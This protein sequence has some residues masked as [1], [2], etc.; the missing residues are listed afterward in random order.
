MLNN[1]KKIKTGSKPVLIFPK[2]V[3]LFQVERST[4]KK[5]L[6]VLEKQNNYSFLNLPEISRKNNLQKNLQTIVLKI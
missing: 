2:T 4:N 1:L 3:K 5:N 6:I